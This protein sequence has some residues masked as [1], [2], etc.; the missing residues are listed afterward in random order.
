MLRGDVREYSSGFSS[1]MGLY[2]SLEVS[3]VGHGVVVVRTALKHLS[4]L[5]GIFLH[6]VNLLGFC[7][8]L[9]LDMEFC[10]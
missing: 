4:T 9:P 7:I 6:V 3:W 10:Y 1:T 2:G 5:S 8:P